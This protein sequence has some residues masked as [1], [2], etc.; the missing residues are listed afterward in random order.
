M[1][2]LSSLTTSTLYEHVTFKKI[3]KLIYPSSYTNI[4]TSVEVSFSPR[5]TIHKVKSILVF[6]GQVKSIHTEFIHEIIKL[7]QWYVMSGKGPGRPE[8]TV[9]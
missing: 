6:D 8:T 1:P 4:P 9:Y 3:Q 7:L 5:R 2:A